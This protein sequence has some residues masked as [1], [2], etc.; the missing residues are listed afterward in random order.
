MNKERLFLRPDYF[1]PRSRVPASF[2]F[3]F[4]D[5]TCPQLMRISAS[6]IEKKKATIE[7]GPCP[8]LDNYGVGASPACAARSLS[9]AGALGEN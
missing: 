8:E 3:V 4:Q 7:G 9:R 5:Y 1:E 6:F 2:D